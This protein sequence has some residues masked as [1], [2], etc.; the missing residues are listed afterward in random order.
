[1]RM[2]MSDDPDDRTPDEG[3]PVRGFPVAEF[4]ARLARAQ[5]GMA[6]TGLDG[7]L[8]TTEPEIRYFTGF[9]TRFWLSPTRPWFVLVPAAG[10]PVAVVP[11]IGR[12]C[13]EATWLD[14]LRCWDS[15]QPHDEGVTLLAEAIRDRFGESPRIG[16][17]EGP[18]TYMRVPLADFR[19]I[20][21]SLP[22]AAFVDATSLVRSL[23][24]VKSPAEIEKIAHACRIISA[25]FASFADQLCIGMPETEIFR[26]FKIACLEA[27]IDDVDYLVGGAGPGGYGNIISPPSERRVRD[28]DILMLDTGAV[29]DGYYCDFDRNYAVGHVPARAARAYDTLMHATETGLHAARPGATC[30]E[31]YRAMKAVIDKAFPGESDVGR[32]GHGLGMQL[33]EWPSFAAHDDT[34][35]QP[36]MVLTLEPSVGL[37]GGAMMVHE[38]NFLLTADGPV[39]LT[40]PAPATLAVID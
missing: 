34:L 3:A 5:A 16:L 10:K 19:R 37:P 32:M 29:F 8:L 25:V 31:V 24:M 39:L 21:A 9:L 40:A 15:P 1:M 17:L 28:G 23:R 35:L 14:D 30:A 38:E 18:E 11:S 36:G 2:I 7:L 12:E 13:F 22:G 4:E 26:R 20:C 33:T 27:G 6:K